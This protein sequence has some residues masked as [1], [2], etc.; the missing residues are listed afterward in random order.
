M[1]EATATT[2][3]R[4]ANGFTTVTYHST[5]VVK[6][7]GDVIIL[8]TGGWYSNTTAKRMNEVSEHFLLGYSVKRRKGE[9]IVTYMGEDHHM[10]GNKITLRR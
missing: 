1:I 9:Y 7:N 4:N 3:K 5:D 8:D 6:F 10:T 2:I